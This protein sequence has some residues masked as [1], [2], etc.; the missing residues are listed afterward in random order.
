VSFSPQRRR[1]RGESAE[2][3][4]KNFNDSLRFLRALGVSAVNTRAHNSLH[5]AP[6]IAFKGTDTSCFQVDLNIPKT[7]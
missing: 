6:D 4:Y 2:E 5:W 1:G 7:L 3:F